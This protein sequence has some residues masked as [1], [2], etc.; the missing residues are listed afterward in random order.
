MNWI[1]LRTDLHSDPAVLALATRMGCSRHQIVGQL[2]DIWGWIGGHTADGSCPN[3]SPEMIDAYIQVPGYASHL[4]EIGWLE[5]SE[6]GVT[7]PKWDRHNSSSAKARAL[8]SEAKAI[9][10]ACVGQVSDK[11]PSKC[12]TREEKRRDIER[13]R[14]VAA[15]LSWEQA[16][17][18]ARKWCKSSP[19]M[20]PYN[21]GTV[22]MWLADRHNKQWQ[23]SSGMVINTKESAERD[24]ENWLTRNRYTPVVV[25]KSTGPQKKEKV[26]A[27]AGPKL[28]DSA[29]DD[30]SWDWRTAVEREFPGAPVLQTLGM[31]PIEARKKIQSLKPNP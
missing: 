24:L 28:I 13:E 4:T 9:R 29:M 6:R 27:V 31:Y 16:H 7:F 22:E 18:H 10:R 30:E 12:R 1:K 25:H 21:S 26:G 15:P 5:V 14:E 23:A 11:S 8:E 2:S 3:V 20:V 19:S 17:E